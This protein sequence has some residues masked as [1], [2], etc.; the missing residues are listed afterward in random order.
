MVRISGETYQ[1]GGRHPESDPNTADQ[2]HRSGFGHRA[3]TFEQFPL[4]TFAKRGQPDLDQFMAGQGA[5]EL[6]R[7]GG[8]YAGCTHGDHGFEVMGERAQVVQLFSAQLHE[9]LFG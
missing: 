1:L 6:R 8:C 3:Q 7:D 4:F 2:L 5:V 9:G